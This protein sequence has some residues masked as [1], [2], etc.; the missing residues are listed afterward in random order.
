LECCGASSA[1]QGYKD[2]ELSDQFNCSTNNPY[3][4]RCGVPF[5]CCRRS[6]ISAE[7]TTSADGTAAAVATNP[8]LPAM[9][10]L[11]CWQ[12]A[13]TKK[14]REL[15]T[16]IYTRGCLH[17]LKSAFER[18][19]VHIGALVGGLIIPVV[20]WICNLSKF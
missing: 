20:S 15:E 16:N 7:S 11:E 12:N 1:A 17:P 14:I 3:P 19:A 6:L 2:W 9:R 8:L 18:H 5:S 10:S 4:E 13:Q